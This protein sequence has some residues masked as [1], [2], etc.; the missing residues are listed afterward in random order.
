MQSPNAAFICRELHR[1]ELLSF[2]AQHRLVT[3]ACA[4]KPCA[5]P[6]QATAQAVQAVV[7]HV[8]AL[9]PLSRPGQQPAP[10]S[11]T[12][13]DARPP[14]IAPECEEGSMFLPDQASRL[15]WVSRSIVGT[16]QPGA[17]IIPPQGC[18]TPQDPGSKQC[19]RQ[20]A[21]TVG[22]TLLLLALALAALT[23]S[24]GATPRA[25]VAP[26]PVFCEPAT[27]ALLA[28]DTATAPQP[29]PNRTR[30]M[31]TQLHH[32]DTTAWLVH[33]RTCLWERFVPLSLSHPLALPL[34]ASANGS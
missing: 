17:D 18:A 4:G 20:L 32:R 28:M 6:R 27:R 3:R 24:A 21:L 19:V 23:A 12:A 13:P 11:P 14:F 15:A 34:P 33:C 29:A 7:R 2:A 8:S 31:C 16:G 25:V 1:Q 5:R 30:A 10:S 9:L 26:P 22:F